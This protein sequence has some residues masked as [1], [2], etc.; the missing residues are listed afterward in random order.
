M[1]IADSK[2]RLLMSIHALIVLI[3]RM[4]DNILVTNDYFKFY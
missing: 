3:N 1:G 2:V 4:K